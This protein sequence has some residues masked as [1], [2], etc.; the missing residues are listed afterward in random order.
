MQSINL[1]INSF[2]DFLFKLSKINETRKDLL[3]NVS[4]DLKTPLTMIK[5]YAETAR[6]LNKNNEKKRE[7]NLNIIIEEAERLNILVNDILELS[8]N[9]SGMETL[10]KERFNLK[11][12]IETIIHRFDYLKEQESYDFVFECEKD[13]FITADKNKITQVIYNLIIN[14]INYTGKDKKITIKSLENNS[15]PQFKAGQK[16]S[17]T[18]KIDDKFYMAPFSL[19]SNPAKSF[20]GEYTIIV[21]KD[22]NNQNIRVI[23][24]QKGE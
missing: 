1:L 24:I 14:A 10:N 20:V 22:E 3:A 12:E 17:V 13:I 19:A 15:F 21:K 9:E 5:A 4:H 2:F 7:E 6:D 8:K 11:S 18:V 23:N 16:I